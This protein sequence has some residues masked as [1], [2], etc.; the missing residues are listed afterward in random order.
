MAEK[1]NGIDQALIRDLA[2]ILNDTDLT[3]I[4]VEQDDL[5]IR[6]SRAGNVQYVQ[7]PMA[8][9]YAPAPAAAAAAPVA[10]APAAPV[11]NPANTISAPMVGTVYMAPAPGARAFIEVG[12]TVKEGQTLLIIEAMKTMNQIPAPK[13]GKVVE[14]LVED[15][16]PVEYGQALVVVE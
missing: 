14:I 10:A 15:G 5:R 11:R 7:A 6:V 12:A 13:S 1:K 4:E 9:G 2:N 8:Q 3:E 16:S